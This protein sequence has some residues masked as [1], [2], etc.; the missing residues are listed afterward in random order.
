[1]L[2]G[3]YVLG[4]ALTFSIAGV[5]VALSGGLFGTALQNPVVL[6]AIAAMLL[7]RRKGASRAAVLEEFSCVGA[8]T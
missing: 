2:A 1:M 8:L 3:I 4:I 7:V 5:A 6:I